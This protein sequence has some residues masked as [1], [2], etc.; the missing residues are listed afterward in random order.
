MRSH[1]NIYN[2]VLGMV[3][4]S[5]LSSCIEN[6]DLDDL[7]PDPK[8]V[9]N[10]AAIA[11]QPISAYL[12]RTWFYCD[13]KQNLAVEN[14]DVR[15]YVN[16]VFREKL[17][18]SEDTSDLLG[19]CYKS[20]YCPKTGDQLKISASAEGYADI[21]AKTDIQQPPQVLAVS[22]H[23]Q[24]E[25]EDGYGWGSDKRCRDDYQ[26]TFRDNPDK[27]NYYLIYFQEASSFQVTEEGDTLYRWKTS[28][29][30]FSSEPIFT[31]HI[32]AFDRVFENYGVGLAGGIAFSD[33]AVNGKTYTLTIK[34][35][36][37]TNDYPGDPGSSTG[38]G[39]G[40]GD[41]PH[42]KSYQ[43]CFFSISRSYYNYLKTLEAFYNSSFTGDLASIGLAE[44]V[45]I[46]SNVAGGTG[47]LGGTSA[48]QV[49]EFHGE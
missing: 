40:D 26:L 42:M 1:R 4:V 32:S 23:H 13:G 20:E 33:D 39:Y 24:H 9:L 48:S 25:V 3:F 37:Y 43:V 8:L 5:L 18:L 44:P 35:R 16:D 34:G 6:I 46:Y 2:V 29:P 31:N 22:V 45:T 49:F 27:E 36:T 30:D 41:K 15:L 10:C 19:P 38:G 11:E 21:E 7:R 28:Y 17:E 14:A 12:S 47:F